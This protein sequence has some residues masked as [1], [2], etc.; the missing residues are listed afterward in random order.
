MA[1][2]PT[3]VGIDVGKDH[4]DVATLPTG[5]TYRVPNDLAGHAE[6]IE[7]LHALDDLDRIVVEATGGYERAVTLALADAGLPVARVN[8]RQTRDFARASGRTAKTDRIDA[9][10]LAEFARALRPPVRDLGNERQHALEDLIHR[11]RQLVVMIGSERQRHAASRNSVVRKSIQTLVA[12][13]E[14]EQRGIERELLRAIEADPGWRERLA[15][16]QSVPGVGLVTALTL[17]AELPELGRLSEKR[18]AA[19][20]GVAP[21]NRDSGR[22]RGQRRTIGGR[23][24]VRKVLYMAA[25]TAT[26]RN[27]AIK[28]FYERLRAAGKP[29]KVALTAC[30]RK[31]LTILN[32]ITKTGRSWE[33]RPIHA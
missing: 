2:H 10:A 24:S 17:L 20:V 13:L 27:P 28:A 26:Q 25:L 4:L 8:P 6:L 16:L 23:S 15:L 5:E 1:E 3:T 9:V 7:R 32:A 12:T 29:A 18:V 14:S 30:M 11:R 19:L 31:L 33:P 22:K 21:M